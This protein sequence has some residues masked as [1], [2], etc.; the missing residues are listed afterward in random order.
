MQVFYFLF[1][2]TMYFFI[3]LLIVALAGMFS[4]RSGITNIALEGIMIMGAFSGIIIINIL[5]DYISGQWLLIIALLIA[6]IFGI[7]TSLL[8]A[9][10]AISLNANQIIAGTAINLFAPAF[11]IFM[12]RIIYDVQQI[13]FVNSFRIGKVPLLNKIPVLGHLLF[14]NTYLTT[15]IGIGIFIVSSI[16][17]YKTKLGLR[18]RVCGEHPQAAASVGVNVYKIRYFGVLL[19]GFLAGMGGLIFIIPTSTSF[20]AS[21][22]GYGFLALAVLIFGQWKPNR[23]LVAAF[24]FSVAKMLASAYTGLDFLNKLPISNNFYKMLP[25]VVT[26]IALIFASKKSQAPKAAGKPYNISQK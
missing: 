9:Y 8:L 21:V 25:Y 14:E 4:E 19:S 7:I 10:S 5:N 23:I 12:A 18:L 15:Y 22:S 2:Q 11:S 20:N 6:G 17:L 3:P 24:F 26:L 16:V 13:T 1:Q